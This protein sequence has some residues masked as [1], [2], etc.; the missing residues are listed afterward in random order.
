MFGIWL[1]LRLELP[2]CPVAD[3]VVPE[4]KGGCE[5][6][7]STSCVCLCNGNVELFV[8]VA[9]IGLDTPSVLSDWVDPRAPSPSS[10][11]R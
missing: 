1:S 2:R 5:V 9:S 3:P 11:G 10:A 6:C 4:V 7:L 8:V